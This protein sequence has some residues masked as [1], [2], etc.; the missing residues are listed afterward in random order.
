[1]NLK[2]LITEDRGVSPVIGVILMVAITVILA[3]VIGAFVLQIGGDLGESAPQASITVS[4]IDA[5]ANNVTLRHG[6]GDTIE[7]DETRIVVETEDN[8]STWTQP[9]AGSF[10]PSDRARISTDGEVDFDP[11]PVDPGPSEF[12]S[13]V[14]SSAEDSDEDSASEF[15][16]DERITIT[17]IDRPSGEIIFDR[18][19]RA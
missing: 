16:S 11:D 4:D 13:P 2:E 1:M 15:D 14:S 5:D 7:W 3:A 8:T 18:T 19:V 17:I 12:F 10:S 6:G 9:D